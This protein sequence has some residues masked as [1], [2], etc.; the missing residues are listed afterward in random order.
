MHIPPKTKLYEMRPLTGPLDPQSSPDGVAAGAHRWVQNFRVNKDGN[1]QRSEGFRRF[2][3]SDSS[4]NNADLHNQFPLNDASTP[5]QIATGTEED[6][7]FL[8]EA[9]AAS[10]DTRLLAGGSK[11]TYV[12]NQKSN[13]W[14]IIRN[15]STATG[16]WKAAQLG[17]DVVF[18]NENEK[19][20]YWK[21]DQ[22]AENSSTGSVREIESFSEIGLNRIRHI[23]EWRGLMFY[24]NVNEGNEWMPDRLIWSDF[25]KPFSVAP[26][27]ESLAGYQDLGPGEDIIGM[28]PL[29]NALL[30][31]TSKGVWQFEVSG[32]T[33]T[34]V[35]S[36]RK[37]YTDEDNGNTIPAYPN[38]IINASDNHFY[39]GRDGI[40]YYNIYRAAPDQPD[41]LK[42][43]SAVIFDG[44]NSS[45]CE[46][47]V[48]AFNARTDEV[49][50]SWPGST[51]TKNSKSI[52][53]NVRHKHV[54]YYDAGFTALSNFVSKAYTSIG[55]WLTT[56]NY[57]CSP[58]SIARHRDSTEGSVICSGTLDLLDT[59]PSPALTSIYS[60]T[61]ITV[62]D[63][64]QDGDDLITEDW[65]AASTSDHSLYG[66]LG[67][68]KFADICTQGCREEPR[69]VM[70]YAKDNCLK[71]DGGAYYRERCTD[72]TG[73]GVYTKDT[74]YKSILRSP[75]LRFN[76]PKNNKLLRALT[77]EFEHAQAGGKLSLRVGNAAQSVD[78]NTVGSKCGLQWRQHDEKAVG[79]VSDIRDLSLRAVEELTWPLYEQGRNL[80]YEL[81]VYGTV[82]KFEASAI[83]LYAETKTS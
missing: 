52:I 57:V 58:L 53:I 48:A 10:G 62:T 9:K 73:C 41:W 13:N 8:F 18:V 20:H 70:A 43:A 23:Q 11:R 76:S 32:G 75:A 4:N 22:P 28:E 38:T 82:G 47:P 67:I 74:G 36:F 64:G 56:K 81:S 55:D 6:I 31:Y 3:Y 50:I 65:D 21:M 2:M 27:E 35:L 30:V 7:T 66:N 79:C 49:W 12:Y 59:I 45:E 19:P 37:R 44:I 78:P 54:T 26:A 80:Y 39:L 34:D 29:G 71:E 16:R 69:F 24:G 68:Q 5:A 15:S 61:S 33:G 14:R 72:K 17:E 25:K 60:T 83:R 1:L 46:A 51:L 40:Y 63:E 77:V 42:D